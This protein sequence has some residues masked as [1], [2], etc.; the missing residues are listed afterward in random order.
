M[1]FAFAQATQKLQ[2][3]VSRK[4]FPNLKS[5]P[6]TNLITPGLTLNPTIESTGYQLS[7]L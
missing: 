3:Q 5:Q 7:R 6:A 4:S 1:N 2:P